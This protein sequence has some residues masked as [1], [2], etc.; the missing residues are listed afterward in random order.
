MAFSNEDIERAL[1]LANAIAAFNGTGLE[2]IKSTG[3]ALHT[4]LAYGIAGETNPDSSNEYLKTHDVANYTFFNPDDTLEQVISAAPAYLY[5]FIGKVGTGTL[6]LRNSATV[7]GSAT[8]LPVFTLAV[9]TIVAFP[10]GLKF[11]IGLTAQCG[12]GTDEAT[13]IWAAQ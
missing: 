9:G 2:D 12:T 1:S 3:N 13:L 4:F 11:D 8:P 10:K 6:T 7:S 5:G